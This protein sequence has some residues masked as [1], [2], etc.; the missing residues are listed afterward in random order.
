MVG[1]LAAAAEIERELILERTQDGIQRA[2]DKG[3]PFGPKRKW[4]DDQALLAQEPRALG[5]SL[6]QISSAIGKPVSTVRRIL[7]LPLA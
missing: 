1:I 6:R 3:V 7:E 5:R 4:G 2:R